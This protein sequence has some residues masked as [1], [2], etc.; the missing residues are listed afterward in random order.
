MHKLGLIHLSLFSCFHELCFSGQ[1][2]LS[3]SVDIGIFV[4][5]NSFNSY[6]QN[7]NKGVEMNE[8]RME[9][10]FSCNMQISHLE[11][12]WCEWVLYCAECRGELY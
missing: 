11:R 7:A 9:R 5:I 10:M 8:A 6:L 2:T 3:T 12:V 1:L 4:F